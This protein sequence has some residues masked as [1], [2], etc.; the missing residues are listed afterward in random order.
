MG[1]PAVSFWSEPEKAGEIVE[2]LQHR[3]SWQGELKAKR[4][5]GS[6]FVAQLSASL[7]LDT[8]GQPVNMMASFV[9]ISHEK[10]AIEE[11][12]QLIEELE[13]KNAELERFTYTVSH[14]LKSPLVTI[15]GFL[16]LLENDIVKGDTLQ[17]QGDIS[18]IRDASETM[19]LLLDDLLELSRVGRSV[20][21]PEE[22][23]LSELARDA[24]KLLASQIAE[25]VVQVDLHP[26]LPVVFGDR[27]RLLE[28]YQNLIQNAVKFMGHQPEPRLEIG[29]KEEE[30]KDIILYVRDNGIGIEPRYQD[31]VFGL[32]DRLDP[33][34]EGTGIG[35]ALVKR[36]VEVHGGRIW[37]ESAGLD[38]GSTFYF[39]L[40]N[41]PAD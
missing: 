4:Q 10:Q 37:V 17:I 21:P 29:V 23:H 35:L 30:G 5:D 2:A 32:F 14:D 28:V 15:K 9:D 1:R 27:P 34:V 26:D 16:G 12:E 24:V 40:P 31:Q 7:V 6:V 20:N 3:N 25:R 13:A 41:E 38:Q 8:S 39:T 36:I 18:H 19:Q 33:G 22:V 11:R